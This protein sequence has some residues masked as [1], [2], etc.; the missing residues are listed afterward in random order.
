VKSASGLIGIGEHVKYNKHT[1]SYCDMKDC[2]Y[3]N[4]KDEKEERFKGL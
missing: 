2:T 3:R 4:L 1:C